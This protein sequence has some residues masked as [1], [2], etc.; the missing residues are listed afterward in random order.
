MGTIREVRLSE[1][2]RDPYGYMVQRLAETLRQ[3]IAMTRIF[4]KNFDWTKNPKQKMMYDLCSNPPSN[5]VQHIMLRGSVGSGKSIAAH[6]W[7]LKT[8]DEYP[9]AHWLGLRNTHDEI[10]TS[11]WTQI[12]KFLKHHQVPCTHGKQPA[13]IELPNGSAWQFW[14]ANAIVQT[15]LTDVAKGL[16]STEF[17]GATLEEADS[18]MQAAVETVPQRLREAS[19]VKSRFMFYPINPPPEN[20]WLVRFFRENKQDN[21][22]DFHEIHMTMEDNRYWLEKEAPG[23]IETQY[24][25]YGHRPA[26]FRRMILG[27]YG[28]E[29]KGDP[30]Y[31]DVF[32]RDFHVYKRTV[33]RQP[34]PSIIERWTAEQMW[35][36]GP[37]CLCWD[38]GWNHPCLLVFQD[39]DYGRFDQIVILGAWLGD[40]ELLRLFANYTLGRVKSMLP[41]AEFLSFCDPAGAQKANG[42]V[43]DQ[44]AIDILEA[45][46]I[47]P[48]HT[49]SSVE[50]GINLTAD[51]LASNYNYGRSGVQ[52]L[53]LVDDNDFTQDV[54]D[55]FELGYVQDPRALLEDQV[56]PLKDGKYEHIFDALRYG[57]IHRRKARKEDY[58]M[59]AVRT[60][61]S[62]VFSKLHTDPE[63]GR[64]Y[65]EDPRSE[66]DFGE[67]MEG[68]GI[69]SPSYSF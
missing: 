28:P 10:I 32:S 47:H 63:T 1:V 23:Y 31:K 45:M 29:A 5:R 36:L 33:D 21:P 35:K 3:T 52:P 7:T 15:S 16:G 25:I 60:Q 50:F 48:R 11:I 26:L 59:R 14:S 69:P 4:Y 34:R 62:D 8:L 56:R 18:I 44:T 64:F 37:V 9:G 17:S 42:G 57:V 13:Y 49:R 39:R 24:A 19:G 6:A 30:I 2:P 43:S 65:V 61:R 41:N 58:T 51:L 40:R 55:G 68:T 46:G 12:R 53:I 38:F 20:H 54:I 66:V 67:L 22:L 27:E